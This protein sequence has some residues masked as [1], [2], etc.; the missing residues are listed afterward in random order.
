[1]CGAV[2]SPVT[3]ACSDRVSMASPSP[4]IAPS[5]RPSTC[6]R[7]LNWMSPW[8]SVPAAI[9]VVTSGAARL[10]LRLLLNIGNLLCVQRIGPREILLGPPHLAPRVRLDAHPARI[11]AGGQHHGRLNLLEI[12]ERKRQTVGILVRRELVPRHRREFAF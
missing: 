3:R 12:L 2:S 5:T 6:R 1:M 9:S 8:I 7:P 11:Q 10:S 4:R